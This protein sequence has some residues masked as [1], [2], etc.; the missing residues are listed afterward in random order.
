MLT[1]NLSYTAAVRFITTKIKPAQITT[2]NPAASSNGFESCKSSCD[3]NYYC[4]VKPI[5]SNSDLGFLE[6]LNLQ[7]TLKEQALNSYIACIAQCVKG[8][9][10]P[11]PK[12]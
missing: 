8:H 1:V 12:Q 7:E 2:S 6:K 5:S 11:N 3:F 10:C 4:D 9:P